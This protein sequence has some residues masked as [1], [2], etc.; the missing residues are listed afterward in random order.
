MSGFITRVSWVSPAHLQ[1]PA[2]GHKFF[3]IFSS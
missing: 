1:L 3:H 2:S